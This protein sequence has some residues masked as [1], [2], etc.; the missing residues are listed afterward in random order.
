M[1]PAF[2][3]PDISGRPVKVMIAYPPLPTEKGIPLLSQNRQFQYFHNPTFIYPMIPAY[4][5]SLL[6]ANGY[7]VVWADGIAEQQ[8]PD[9]FM[10][11]FDRE[12]PNLVAIEVKTPI[13]KRY[14]KWIDELKAAFPKT[15]YV[16]IGDHVTALPEESLE[17]SSVDIV[18]TGG[19]FDLALLNLVNHLAKG[20]ALEGGIYYRDTEGQIVNTGKFESHEITGLPMID[21]QLTRWE[22]YAYNNGNYK[23][24]PGTYTMVG[25]DCWWRKDGGCTFCSWTTTFPKFRVRTPEQ[26]LN[27]VGYLISLGVREIFDDTGTFPVGGWLE[28]FCHGMIERGY[29]KKVRFGCNM[30]PGALK[31]PQY[32]MM[33]KASFRFI[34]YGLESAN[35][36][37]LDLINKGQEEN[38]MWESARMAKKA[39]LEPHVTCMVGYPWETKADAESTI[40]L[41]KELF[42]RGWIDTLQATIVIPYPGTQ[43]FKECEERGWLRTRDWDRYDMREPIMTCPIP[44]AE[45]LALTQGLYKSF[46]TPRFILRKLLATRTW[47]D[48]KFLWRG[49]KYVIG[50]LMD[51]GR[52][53][54]V[55]KRSRALKEEP[56]QNC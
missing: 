26:L 37:T 50:H 24:T 22:L 27:E 38:A 47:D 10:E 21:R 28:R 36:R 20:E 17:H 23:Y 32:E 44:D 34:L 35:R 33:G 45:V 48:V 31:P 54:L 19:D 40:C 41:T 9:Q 49:V 51:F 52:A 12:R 18:L 7:D 53:N 39:G 1:K 25:R 4:A 15:I 30:R 11:M 14:W 29:H 46:L 3:Y 6:K 55:L 56:Q 43:L 42:A 13:V 16:L 5:A 2:A 8:T